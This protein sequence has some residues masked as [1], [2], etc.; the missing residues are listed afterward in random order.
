ME[1]GLSPNSQQN[2]ADEAHEEE[3]ED[4]DHEHYGAGHNFDDEKMTV[5]VMVHVQN[6]LLPYLFLQLVD[7]Q[8]WTHTLDH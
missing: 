4:E 5:I 8:L 3:D 6:S 2:V 7:Q 1:F